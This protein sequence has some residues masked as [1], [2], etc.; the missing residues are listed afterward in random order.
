MGYITP[1]LQSSLSLVSRN[2]CKK[3]ILLFF[4]VF[5]DI[6]ILRYFT[7]EK[8]EL[9]E[10]GDKYGIFLPKGANYYVEDIGI[11]LVQKYGV[12]ILKNVAKL[13]FSNTERILKEVRK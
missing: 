4:Y 13:N 6:N 10:I 1:N 8:R 7:I 12:D 2:I 9:F 3:F 11:K 5:Y